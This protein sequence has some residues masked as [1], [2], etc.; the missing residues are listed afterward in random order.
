MGS[1]V[2]LEKIR[3]GEVVLGLTLMYPGAG[4]IE[5]MCRGWDFVWI[6]GQHGQL[7]YDS[8]LEAVRAADATGVASM[9]R[10]PGHEYGILGPIA[11]LDPAAIMV[12]M[13]NTPEDAQTVVRGLRF[14][15]LGERSF[16]GRRVIDHHGREYY[17]TCELMVVAQIETLEAVE[18]AEQIAAIEGIDALFFGPDDMKVRM[19]LPI[20]TPPAEHPQLRQAMERTARAARSAGKAVAGVATTAQA[21]QAARSMGYQMFAAGADVAFLRVAAADRLAEMRGATDSGAAPSPEETPAGDSP[22]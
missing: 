11:D 15:P 10:V 14:P 5:G 21:V 17:Q 18:N 3:R 7:S 2:L 13:V 9:V 12:P 6:D 8:V 22:Y 4:I 16:G 20:N 19:G 1:N